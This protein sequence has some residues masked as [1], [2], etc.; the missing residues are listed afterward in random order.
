MEDTIAAVATAYGEG[1]IG[2]IR[3]SGEEALPILQEIFEF[4]GDTD[5]FTSR[6]MTYGKIIDK[7]KNQIIDEVLAVYM[8]GPKTYTAEDVVEINCHGSMVSLR[9]TLALVL[10]KGARLAEPGEFTKRAFLN[11]RLDLSQAEAVIDMIRAKTDKSFDVAVSQLEGRL[12]LKVE[13]IRQK[14]L[15]LLVDITV[16]IDYPDEDIEEMTY[17]KLEESIVETQD[18]IEKLLETSST[19]KMIREGIK[20]AIV[21]KPNV[22]KSSLMNGLLKETRA[23]V[24]DIPGTTRDT[25]EE[26]LS[27]RNIPV[28]LVDTAGIRE[29][30]DKVEKMGIEKSKEAFN[31]ADFILFLLDGSRSLEEEDLQIMEFLKERKCLVLINKRDLGEAISIEEISAKLPASQVIEASLLK[32]Q[33]ITEIEDAVEDLVYGGE[34]VQKESMMVNNVRHIELLQ[35]AVKSLTDAL[36]MSERR[37]ALDF[38][39]VDVKNAYERLGEI[40]GETVSDDIINEVFARFCLGK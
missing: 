20:I 4:H 16:N 3:I 35:Q 13:E 18:M 30:S 8:K 22:G 7:E 21:G 26:V 15:D 40:I 31:Q 12:S 27:I 33:G 25:I 1:G 24:T 29:T 39:E 5:T 6:R 28:Y 17:E 34:I 37:E 32:G 11:G 9:K 2:I 10:R 14:L 19:G 36:H 23:I 38:I